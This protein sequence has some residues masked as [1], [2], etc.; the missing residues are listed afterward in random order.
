MVTLTILLLCII[1]YLLYRLDAVRT[2]KKLFNQIVWCRKNRKVLYSYISSFQKDLSIPNDYCIL[3]A[4]DLQFVEDILSEFIAD[5]EASF[6]ASKLTP[7]RSKYV[8]KESYYFAWLLFLFLDKH[9]C[10]SDVAGHNMHEKEISRQTYGE[11]IPSDW[12]AT[13]AL[14]PFG[15]TYCK[16]SY[17]LFCFISSKPVFVKKSELNQEPPK[18]IKQALDAKEITIRYRKQY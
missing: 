9:W 3:D 1:V 11:S 8:I 13:Y 7:L 17:I 16:L 15:F 12:D 14:T 2:E 4:H 5:L 6:F 10:D 18:H